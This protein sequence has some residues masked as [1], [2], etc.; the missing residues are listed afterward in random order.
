[1]HPLAVAEPDIKEDFMD[2]HTPSD[3]Q[4]Q[5]EKCN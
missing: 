2:F 1:M 4:A 3:Y 5:A